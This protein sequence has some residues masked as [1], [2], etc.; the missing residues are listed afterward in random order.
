MIIC[1]CFNDQ[2]MLF[3][4]LIV[5]VGWLYIEWDRNLGNLYYYRYGFNSRVKDKFDIMVCDELRILDN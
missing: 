4:N 3:I 5:I 2:I 1:I